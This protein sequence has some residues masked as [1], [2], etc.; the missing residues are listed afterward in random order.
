M[1]RDP[2]VQLIE[3]AGYFSIAV[4]V[5]IVAILIIAL[6]I[7]F[8]FRVL[9]FPIDWLASRVKYIAA[10]AVTWLILWGCGGVLAFAALMVKIA[11]DKLV[12]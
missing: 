1:N 12:V 8:L 6:L 2:L 9:D 10:V 7:V 11:I 3:Q 5:V 4:F